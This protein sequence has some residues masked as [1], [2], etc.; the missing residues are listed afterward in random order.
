MGSLDMWPPKGLTPPALAP[1]WCCLTVISKRSDIQSETGHSAQTLPEGCLIPEDKMCPLWVFF[2]ISQFPL[3]ITKQLVLHVWSQEG[4]DSLLLHITTE[5]WKQ[6][7]PCRGSKGGAESGNCSTPL[8]QEGQ[9][10]GEYLAWE[11]MHTTHN[12]THVNKTTSCWAFAGCQA[13]LR[14]FHELS[15]LLIS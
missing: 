5:S 15:H 3:S 14:A 8:T 2:H 11:I 7:A 13:L 4:M 6:S 10:S 9:G 12:H 1:Y